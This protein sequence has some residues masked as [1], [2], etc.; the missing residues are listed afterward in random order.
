MSQ[1]LVAEILVV[2]DSPTDRLLTERALATARIS[3]RV[4]CVDDGIEAMAFLRR[5]GRHA[6][7][8]RP[9]LVLLDL[10][11]PGMSGREVL[12]QMKA[13]PALRAIPVVVL[14]TSDRDEDIADV[15][16]LHANC[17]VQKPIS[18]APFAAIIEK[19]SEFWFA[20]VTLPPR[21]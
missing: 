18:Y 21:A 7:A 15:Y 2:E 8:P 17:L 13:D 11:L 19:I 4:S 1:T 5:E 12:A 14:T 3:N 20:T 6:A 16:A 10:N 9:Q